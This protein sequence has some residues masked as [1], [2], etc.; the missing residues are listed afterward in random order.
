[1]WKRISA[2]LLDAVALI[3]VME[4]LF[5]LFSAA[6]GFNTYLE[7]MDALEEKYYKEYD[8]ETLLTDEQ[9]NALTK[10]EQDAYLKKLQDADKAYQNDPEVVQVYAKILSLSLMI[11]TFS[12]LIAF[13]VL[14]FALPLIFKNG[15]TLGKKVFGIA[16][17]RVDGIK[18]TPFMTFARGILGKCTIGT[19]VPVYLIIM[20]VFGYMGLVGIVAFV[21]LLL[22]QL[23]M[24]ITTK[25]H[26]PIHDK[27]AM[28]IAVDM[29]TQMIFD[30]VEEKE[31][32][33]KRITAER[34][35]TYDR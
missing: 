8:I 29:N 12:I 7:R 23:V 20:V 18:I 30:S 10:E 4:A 3:L 13:L 14:E 11:T 9:Y 1:M 15:Q 24:F 32:Y 35:D 33:L 5:L 27:L 28:T 6:F 21:G 19:L 2:G 25:Y 31:A 16:V 22:F 34:V 17:M 26:T